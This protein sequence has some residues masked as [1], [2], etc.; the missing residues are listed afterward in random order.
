MDADGDFVVTWESN[1]GGGY[2][3]YARRYV[4]TATAEYQQNIWQNNNLLN[5]PPFIPVATN[6]L[7]GFNGE[8]G[9]EFL[10][11]STTAG[12]QRYPSVGM[13]DTGDFIIVWSGQGQTASQGVF[14]QRFVKVTDDAPPTVTDVDYI[15]GNTGN[16]N[17]L[18]NGDTISGTT[19][20]TKFVV[21]LGENVSTTGGAREPTAF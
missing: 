9:G 8:N 16:I 4:S 18:R 6:P 5:L 1:S 3:I 2:D 21:T 10:V 17:Q 7:Y 19:P 20:V 14:Y 12:D 11:N 15:D 13:D